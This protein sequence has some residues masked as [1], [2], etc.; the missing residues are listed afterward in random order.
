MDKP[1]KHGNAQTSKQEKKKTKALSQLQ[2]YSSTVES[3]DS[4]NNLEKQGEKIGRG[5]GRFII[6]NLWEV[7]CNE[8]DTEIRELNTILA[9]LG[10]PSVYYTKSKTYDITDYD[11]P[12]NLST[13][14]SKDF[15]DF[16]VFPYV[17][18]AI[19]ALLTFARVN[20]V[21][22][23]RFCTFNALDY[24]VEYLYNNNPRYPDRLQNPV[25]IFEIP[26]AK[27][28]LEKHPRKP[29][30]KW[31]LMSSEEA[32]R[33]I[34]RAV[35]GYVVRCRPDVQEMRQFWKDYRK[36]ME[37]ERLLYGRNL[38]KDFVSVGIFSPY[39]EE[40]RGEFGT[41]SEGSPCSSPRGFH[42]DHCIYC[43]AFRDFLSNPSKP[44]PRNSESTV[45]G[46]SKND[47]S[48]T[49]GNEG[50]NSQPRSSTADREPQ[51]TTETEETPQIVEQQ[52]QTTKRNSS[53][54]PPPP[55]PNTGSKTNKTR[56]QSVKAVA[57]QGTGTGIVGQNG[58]SK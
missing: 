36:D 51:P 44:E 25:P 52:P 1:K 35:R 20:R 8:T 58:K 45:G 50:N 40:L 24:I 43:R 29:P 21:F 32:A 48:A 28:W 30:P 4:L 42:S 7:C 31:M 26:F 49:S 53:D 10:L 54:P 12:P 55:P 14:K 9:K 11:L 13:C 16:Y 46:M 41:T 15:L 38:P 17:L 22:Q 47:V 37:E 23:C 5:G 27:A 34:Q 57:K 3:S 18:P 56:K 33:I 19:Q 6:K 39:Y 2:R